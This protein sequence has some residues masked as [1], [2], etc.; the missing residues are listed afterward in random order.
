VCREA[1]GHGCWLD[2]QANQ[3]RLQALHAPTAV[4]EITSNITKSTRSR[5]ALLPCVGKSAANQH[6]SKDAH[7]RKV[8]HN[9]DC[10]VRSKRGQARFT[11]NTNLLFFNIFI[12]WF[13]NDR[14]LTRHRA[15][16]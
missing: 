5:G 13:K 2:A 12:L 10:S 1:A 4:R 9:R 16:E 7:C 3:K 8:D 6:G 15:T 11:T 14:I